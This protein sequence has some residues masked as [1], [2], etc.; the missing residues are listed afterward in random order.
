MK[1]PFKLGASIA[2]VVIVI[3]QLTKVWA[4][5]ALTLYQ[6]KPVF[7]GLNL[8]LAHNPGIAF[9]MFD[10]S[11]DLGRWLLVVLALVVSL[12]LL[13]WLWRLAQSERLVA[14]AIG[15]ILGGALGNVVDRIL[16]GYVIDFI[17]VYYRQAHW[18]AFNIADSAIS[19]G[20]VLLIWD[21]FFGKRQPQD[22]PA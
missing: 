6:A 5:N 17:D 18:P 12:V 15:F 20:A 14:L 13:L 16:L 19:V 2:L 3:D 4:S 1:L 11:G 21:A 22:E 9:S 8:T 10:D 7:T